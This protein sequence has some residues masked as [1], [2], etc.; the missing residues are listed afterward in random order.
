MKIYTKGGDRGETSLAGGRRVAKNSPKVEAYGEVDELIA[1]LGLIKAYHTDANEIEGVRRVQRALMSV[2]AL[3]ASD[4]DR[5]NIKELDSKELLFLEES[6]D[7]V[8]AQLPQQSAFILPGAPPLSALYHIARTIC[9]RAERAAYAMEI[10]SGQREGVIYLN[11]LSDWLYINGR[12]VA[13]SAGV[14][15]DYWHQ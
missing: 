12:K 2:A 10:D 6:I 1:H 5:K 14:E 3:F 15:E 11:R 7:M 9:R 13:H 8:S 4:S